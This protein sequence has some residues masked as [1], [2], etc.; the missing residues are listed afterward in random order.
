MVEFGIYADS[1]SLSGLNRPKEGKT[2]VKPSSSGLVQ[3]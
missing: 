1:T 3:Q 2:K